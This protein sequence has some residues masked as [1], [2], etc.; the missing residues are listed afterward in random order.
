VKDNLIKVVAATPS[1]RVASP[2]EN[3]R[4]IVELVLRAEARGAKLV[5]MSELCVT[6]STCGDLFRQEALLS[7]TENAVAEIAKGTAQTD[8]LTVIG[9]P[10]ACDGVLLNTAIVLHK[11]NVLGIAASP[12]ARGVFG[13]GGEARSV[14][15]A[16]QT[17]V[18]GADLLFR[19]QGLDG[20]VLACEIGAD[21]RSVIP[22]SSASVLRGANVIAHLDAA[23]ETPSGFAARKTAECF[24]SHSQLAARLCANA[25]DGESTTDTVFA[26]GN[27]I[28][29]RGELLSVS[30]PFGEAWAE[31]E[32]DLGY[33]GFARRNDSNFF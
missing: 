7:A 28:A 17:T 3:A 6:G 26:A 27:V 20:V 19:A 5:V 4:S 18:L 10:V 31:S 32:I 30:E 14:R 1:I 29:E 2:T 15:Y 11:G 23:A 13:A 24:L 16:G 21:A 25:G 22:A 12:N 8:V 33:L 9:A